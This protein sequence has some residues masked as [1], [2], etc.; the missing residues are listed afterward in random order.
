MAIKAWT[1]NADYSTVDHAVQ[2]VDE[3]IDLFRDFDWAEQDGAFDLGMER[4][5][6]VCPPGVGF[7]A[8]L[9]LLHIYREE[10]GRWEI[11]LRLEKE[12]G[13]KRLFGSTREYNLS[14][15]QESDIQTLIRLYM[16]GDFPTLRQLG[17]GRA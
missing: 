9:N 7:T 6:D 17:S 2:S 11:L 1:Q 3:A 13:W 12:P 16:E 14:F 10:P 5:E 4:G 8:G 15:E